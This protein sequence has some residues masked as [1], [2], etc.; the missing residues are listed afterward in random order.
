MPVSHSTA[1]IRGSAMTVNSYL[2]GLASSAIIR[3]EE[4]ISIRRSIANLQ[5]KLANEFHGELADHFIFGSYSRGT[6]LPRFMD[7]RSDID[8]MVVFKDGSLRPQ[9][10]LS[11]LRRFVERNYTRSEIY[12]SNPTVVLALNHINFELVPAID[13]WMWGL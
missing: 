8:Y 10:Y 12:Q 4:Q 9:S 2:A 1:S 13:S 6:I 3:N 7:E 5:T 11:R